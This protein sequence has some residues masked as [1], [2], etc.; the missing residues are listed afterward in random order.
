MRKQCV[1]GSFFSAHAQEPGNEATIRVVG[2]IQHKYRQ[3]QLKHSL[4]NSLMYATP[5]ILYA[6]YISEKSLISSSHAKS[7]F[8][9]IFT[10][11]L[12]G[13]LIMNSER[14]LD[15]HDNS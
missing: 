14:Q 15:N 8:N 7:S 3:I 13:G 10:S 12:S 4:N 6:P 11:I 5:I 9:V 1:P 2:Q